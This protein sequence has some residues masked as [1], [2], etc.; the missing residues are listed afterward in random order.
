MRF[1]KKELNYKINLRKILFIN[2]IGILNY[3]LKILRVINVWI[4]LVV[5][6]VKYN[7]LIILYK[8]N[9]FFFLYK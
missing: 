6:R 9:G 4:L 3:L 5:I 8:N 7:Y 1:L 2:L